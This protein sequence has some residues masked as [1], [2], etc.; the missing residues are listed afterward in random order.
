MMRLIFPL[1]HYIM[2][3]ISYWAQQVM[4]IPQEPGETRIFL[5]LSW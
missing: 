5:Q 1:V 3:I 4:H 2:Y